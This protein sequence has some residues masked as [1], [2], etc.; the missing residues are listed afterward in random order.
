M[1]MNNKLFVLAL[2]MAAVATFD[3]SARW[4]D[5]D[6]DEHRGV[7]GFITDTVGGVADAGVTAVEGVGDAAVDLTR[8][9]V[10]GATGDVI[11]V[12]VDAPTDVVSGVTG[13]DLGHPWRD[14]YDGDYSDSDEDMQDGDDNEQE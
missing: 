6:E 14:R 11:G 4:R 3:C 12:G 8:G 2:A 9:D 13:R 1:K 10:I 7:G 5:R